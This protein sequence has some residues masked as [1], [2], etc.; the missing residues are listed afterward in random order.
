MVACAC[1]SQGVYDL[2]ADGFTT[3]IRHEHT[4][5]GGKTKISLTFPK[6][7]NEFCL[8]FVEGSMSLMQID[9]FTADVASNLIHSGPKAGPA[10]GIIRL[11]GSYLDSRDTQPKN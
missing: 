5:V 6:P 9:N 1:A 10:P 3:Q 2:E 4:Q 11:S 7:V 8:R